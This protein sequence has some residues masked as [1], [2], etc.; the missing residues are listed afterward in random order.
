MKTKL[1][2]IKKTT[3]IKLCPNCGHE[4]EKV[5]LGYNCPICGYFY[6]RGK[7]SALVK[8]KD[9]CDELWREI[10]K[11]GGACEICGQPMRDPHHV[12]GK[13]NYALRW[14]I[15]NGVRLC[16]T[17]HTGGNLS[18]HNDPFWFKNWFKKVRPDDY[19]YLLKKKN[20]VWD[21]DYDKV[22]EYLE[23]LHY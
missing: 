15:R 6:V 7:K 3:K 17:H 20:E 19:E 16:F 21:K 12:I 1:K 2:P 14:D 13:K 11:S 9:K 8:A 4:L 10:I 5:R 18:A 22:L 23:N